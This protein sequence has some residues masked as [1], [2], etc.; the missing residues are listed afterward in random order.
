MTT[1]VGVS[2]VGNG[3]FWIGVKTP[4]LAFNCSPVTVEARLLA[5]KR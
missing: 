4:V 5:V 3:V 1:L 2:E